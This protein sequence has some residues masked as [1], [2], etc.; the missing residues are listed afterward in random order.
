MD[1]TTVSATSVRQAIADYDWRP[2]ATA[3][4][5]RYVVL[6]LV[7]KTVTVPA[8]DVI[9]MTT[10]MAINIIITSGDIISQSGK[11]ADGGCPG[12]CANAEVALHTTCFGHTC[13]HGT[14]R[15]QG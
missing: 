14:V 9:L 11:P 4:R 3:C 2:T 5:M 7:V 10:V 1:H 8:L 13:C 15:C 6:F 12:T